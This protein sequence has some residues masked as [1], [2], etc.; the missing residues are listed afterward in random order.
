M[1]VTVVSTA[2]LAV[3]FPEIKNMTLEEINAKFGDEVAVNLKD[4]IATEV[5]TDTKDGKSS[6]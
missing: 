5:R 4:A 1:A 2:V 6:V 3:Y